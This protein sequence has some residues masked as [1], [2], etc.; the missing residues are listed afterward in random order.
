MRLFLGVILSLAG[1]TG[2]LLRRR[3]AADDEVPADTLR[4]IFE[5]EGGIGRGAVAAMFEERRRFGGI[6]LPKET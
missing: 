3:A 5:G 2:R 1:G 6:V 4:G